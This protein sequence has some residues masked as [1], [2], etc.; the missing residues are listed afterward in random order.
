[1]ELDRTCSFWM[2]VGI[3]VN[4]VAGIHLCWAFKCSEPVIPTEICITSGIFTNFT[5]ETGII[6]FADYDIIRAFSGLVR[7]SK[8]VIA[9]DH[10]TLFI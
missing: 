5:I 10:W 7:T 1:M 8:W 3:T 6:M 4:I 2:V 9:C